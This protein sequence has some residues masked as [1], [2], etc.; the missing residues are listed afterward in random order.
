MSAQV[1]KQRKAAREKN[2][3]SAEVMVEQATRARAA[4]R[5]I[6]V[7][8]G[9]VKSNGKP[10]ECV[11]VKR[12]EKKREKEKNGQRTFANQGP[13]HRP[14]CTKRQFATSPML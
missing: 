1:L 7:R 2:A 12:G 6:L 5:M 9:M 10:N 3:R 8:E 13:L 14:R 4:E 11:E